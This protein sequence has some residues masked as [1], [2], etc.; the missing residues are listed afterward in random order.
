MNKFNSSPSHCIN[1]PNS[2]PSKRASPDF[3]SRKEIIN[4][5]QS[6]ERK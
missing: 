4:N 1:F 5:S 2:N 6:P 3:N